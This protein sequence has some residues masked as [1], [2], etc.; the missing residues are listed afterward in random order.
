MRLASAEACAAA[1]YL[2][3]SAYLQVQS[4]CKDVTLGSDDC[5]PVMKHFGRKEVAVVNQ[6]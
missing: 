2:S 6:L 1:S 4:H 3:H 5:A